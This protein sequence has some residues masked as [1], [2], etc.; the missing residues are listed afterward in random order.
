MN[1]VILDLHLCESLS[2]LDQFVQSVVRADLKEDINVFVVLEHMFELN[3]MIVIER[4]MD[5]DFG[6]EL[7]LDRWVLFVWLWIGLESF[8]R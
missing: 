2:P 6:N 7:C 4:F 5:F 8:W 1:K 3:Y